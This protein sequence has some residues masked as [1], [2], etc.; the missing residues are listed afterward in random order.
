MAT[1]EAKLHKTEFTNEPFVDFSKPENRS[2]MEAALKKVA[3]EFGREYPMYIAGQKVTTAEKMKSTNPS[4]PSQV[5]GIV[6]KASAEQA[7]QAIESAHA[8][9]DTWKR[10]PAEQR[11]EILFRAAAIIRQRKFET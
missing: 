4:H 2:A 8:Y 1:A 3:S 6:Q 10:V 5:V 11:A 7:R 9:F